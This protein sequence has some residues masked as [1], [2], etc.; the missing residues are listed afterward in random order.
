MHLP[1]LLFLA[2]PQGVLPLAYPKQR[3]PGTKQVRKNEVMGAEKTFTQ[4]PNLMRQT[5]DVFISSMRVGVCFKL[6]R[7]FLLPPPVILFTTPSTAG[8]PTANSHHIQYSRG[9]LITF[10]V[11]R[12]SFLASE[13]VL[14]SPRS[15]RSTSTGSSCNIALNDRPAGINRSIPGVVRDVVL[16]LA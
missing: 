13:T 4:R 1:L 15:C 3:T 16:G 8:K 9:T 10:Q 5:A 2:T 6:R 7:E 14:P 12:S 11:V